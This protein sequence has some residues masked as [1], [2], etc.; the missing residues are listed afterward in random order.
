MLRQPRAMAW[1]SPDFRSSEEDGA[2]KG[3][4]FCVRGE[5]DGERASASAASAA[6]L[7]MQNAISPNQELP[8]VLMVP[9]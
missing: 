2:G 7:A 5:A 1:G 8:L 9:W 3:L 4:W 6:V